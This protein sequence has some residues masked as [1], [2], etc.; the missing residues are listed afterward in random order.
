MSEVYDYPEYYEIAFSWRDIP[1]EVDLFEECIRRFSKIQV[2]SVLEIG[3][4]NSPHME[5]L[6]K[7]G[8]MSIMVLI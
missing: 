7:R 3:C 4:G 5:E 1:T 8:Y 6:I 2:K